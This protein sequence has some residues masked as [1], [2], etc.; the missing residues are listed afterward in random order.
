[1]NS[2]RRLLKKR[3]PKFLRQDGHK[4]LKLGNKWRRP[5]GI[6]NKL[7]L[8]LRGYRRMISPG[9]KSPRLVRGT[10]RD[11]LRMV[12]VHTAAEVAVLKPG[13][14]AVIGSTVGKRSRL[15]I[16]KIAVEKNIQILNM[17]D[18][19]GFIKS[20]EDAIDKKKKAKAA[21]KAAEKKKEEK[22]KAEAKKKEEEKKAAEKKAAEPASIEDKIEDEAEEK[23]KQKKKKK[24]KILTKKT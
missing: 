21:K 20:I 24:D 12:T 10:S 1:L 4:K 14:T 17:K 7:R 8:G 23:K 2:I 13:E 6:D 15:D 19:A 5:R 11:G 22:K 18:P 3:K 9:F 16:A